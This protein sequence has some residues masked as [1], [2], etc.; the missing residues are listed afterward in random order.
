MK[1]DNKFVR[2]SNYCTDAVQKELDRFGKCGYR[3]VSTEM[4]SNMHDCTVMY[5]FFTKEIEEDE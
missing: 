4:A 5:L 1:Y 3:L 2:V